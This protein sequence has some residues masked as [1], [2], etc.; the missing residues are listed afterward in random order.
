MGVAALPSTGER[1]VSMSKE[2]CLAL[3]ERFGVEG[4][5]HE[6]ARFSMSSR[7]GYTTFS[8]NIFPRSNSYA[9]RVYLEARDIVR[10]AVMGH[11]GRDGEVIEY[12]VSRGR[13]IDGGEVW[14]Y[15]LEG[16]V[17]E[18]YC[19]ACESVSFVRVLHE[20][21][22]RSGREWVSVDVDENFETP[23]FEEG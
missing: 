9:G 7:G 8:T 15:V 21:D 11:V 17:V 20:Q 23:W 2:I 18:A 22:P 14:F 6:T 10:G 19:F 13:V 4:E 16:T 5:Y 12:E 1:H 3:S